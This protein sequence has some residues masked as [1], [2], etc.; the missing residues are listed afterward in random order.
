[1]SLDLISL[2][3]QIQCLSHWKGENRKRRERGLENALAAISQAAANPDLLANRVSAAIRADRG[4]RIAVPLTEPINSAVSRQAL[5]ALA[6]LVAVDGSQMAPNSHDEVPFGV[7]NL[8]AIRYSYGGASAPNVSHHTELVYQKNQKQFLSDEYIN[9]LRDLEE[10]LFLSRVTS[11]ID[12][13][14]IGLIDGGIELWNTRD[15]PGRDGQRWLAAHQEFMKVMRNQE[16]ALAGYIDMPVASPVIQLLEFVSD[17]SNIARRL[18][19]VHFPGVTDMQLF[20]RLLAPG[21]RSAVFGMQSLSS[22][23]YTG[24]LALRFFYLNVGTNI[25]PHIARVE[26]PDWVASNPDLLNDLHAVL[27]NQCRLI[28]DYAYP[29]ALARAHEECVVSYTD[30]MIV[31]ALIE[32]YIQLQGVDSLLKTAKNQYKALF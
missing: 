9:Q 1:M 21:E 10:R 3:Q 19:P 5:P 16:A 7:I 30:Q 6:T 20:R 17:K 24:V 4:I 18:S 29:Y 15:T 32:G 22:T 12:G 8:A 2:T 14:L 23:R 13:R 27:M 11:K 31:R 26:I 25:F 28:E